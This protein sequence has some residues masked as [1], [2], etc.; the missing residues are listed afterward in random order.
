MSIGTSLVVQWLRLHAPYAGG[1]GSIPS[2]GTRSHMPQLRLNAAKYI[3]LNIYYLFGYMWW[4]TIVYAYT[5]SYWIRRIN[6]TC[7]VSTKQQVCSW[8]FSWH[9][10]QSQAAYRQTD[11]VRSGSQPV[12]KPRLAKG[13]RLKFTV[14]RNMLVYFWLIDWWTD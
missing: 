7:W 2:Q 6:L 11:T 12:S 10:L 9:R 3:F 13:N 5:R 14:D 1:P 8:C 4:V